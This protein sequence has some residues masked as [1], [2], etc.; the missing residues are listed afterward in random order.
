MWTWMRRLCGV[1]ILAVVPWIYRTGN[2]RSTFVCERPAGTCVLSVER[3]SVAPT[4]QSFRLANVLGA[5]YQHSYWVESPKA[6][7]A[8]ARARTLDDVNVE[9]LYELAPGPSKH[10]F[11]RIVVLTR[12]GLVPMTPEFSSNGKTSIHAFNRFIRGNAQDHFAMV[13]DSAPHRRPEHDHALLLWR[14]PHRVGS[15]GRSETPG[16]QRDGF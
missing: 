1:A 7:E 13:E 16:D 6:R 4:T 2:V 5:E 3:P 12:Q 10:S 8:L 14:P 11:E 15:Q 9:D